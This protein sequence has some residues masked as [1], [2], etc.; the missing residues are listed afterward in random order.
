M[1]SDCPPLVFE[2][3]DFLLEKS[4]LLIYEENSNLGEFMRFWKWVCKLAYVDDISAYM[5]R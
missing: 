2:I 3:V 1:G 5:N 4:R